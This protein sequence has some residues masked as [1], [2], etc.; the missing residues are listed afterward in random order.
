MPTRQHSWVRT[1]LKSA[2]LLTFLTMVPAAS[3]AFEDHPPTCRIHFTRSWEDLDAS[4][5]TLPKSEFFKQIKSA[6]AKGGVRLEAAPFVPWSRATEQVLRG[7]DHGLS[8]ALKTT[9]RQEELAFL[10]PIFET[11]WYA[12]KIKGTG[13]R[14]LI[15]AKI[16]VSNS[17]A[18]LEPIVAA[19]QAFQGEIIGMPAQRLGR[20]L[21]E[22]RVD[23]IAWPEYGIDYLQQEMQLELERS[24]GVAFNVQTFVAVR[25]DAP[26]MSRRVQLNEALRAWSK[27]DIAIAYSKASP[28]TRNVASSLDAGRP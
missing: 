8:L 1:A 18:K 28:L 14:D 11:T 23:A 25:K 27:T 9:E 16:G 21:K 17:Y 3:N 5:G 15:G 6:F 22:Q 12:Y 4:I 19:I 24:S 13:E 2:L 10:G 7:E 26:C 20:M